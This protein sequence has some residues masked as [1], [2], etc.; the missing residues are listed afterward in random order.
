MVP[1]LTFLNIQVQIYKGI[2][3]DNIL[4][5]NLSTL[6]MPNRNRFELPRLLPNECLVARGA[7]VRFTHRQPTFQIKTLSG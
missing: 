6:N 4:N 7:Y 1:L 3:E 5:K 2:N